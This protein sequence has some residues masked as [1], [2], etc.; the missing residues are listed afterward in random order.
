MGMI[1]MGHLMMVEPDMVAAKAV[2]VFYYL[3]ST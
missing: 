2:K 3:N 1:E